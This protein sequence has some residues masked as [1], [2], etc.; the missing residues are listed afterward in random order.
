MFTLKFKTLISFVHC[1]Y[2]IS[3]CFSNQVNCNDFHKFGLINLLCS[4][5]KW[6]IIYFFSK[7]FVVFSRTISFHH[8]KAHSYLH[9]LLRKM[10]KCSKILSLTTCVK[11][12]DPTVFYTARLNEPLSLSAHNNKSKCWEPSHTAQK[13]YFKSLVQVLVLELRRVGLVDRR[14]PNDDRGRVD[15]LPVPAPHKL[16]RPRLHASH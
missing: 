2:R 4:Y 1:R 3:I 13:E 5:D 7:W 8:L 6:A 12:A 14:L 16:C 9:N 10:Q 11:L 15:R